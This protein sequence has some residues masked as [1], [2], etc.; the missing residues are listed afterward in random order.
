MSAQAMSA[1]AYREWGVEERPTSETGLERTKAVT[2]AVGLPRLRDRVPTL[3]K[4]GFALAT[5]ALVDWGLA[6]AGVPPGL[7]GAGGALATVQVMTGVV[8][9]RLAGAVSRAV[10]EKYQ[11]AEMADRTA[12]YV[13]SHANTPEDEQAH[14][15]RY[16]DKTERRV[17]EKRQE[18]GIVVRTQP[19]PPDISR[20][21]T[22][23]TQ[24]H[25][26]ATTTPPLAQASLAAEIEFADDQ[27]ELAD[28]DW[29]QHTESL[30]TPSPDPRA[31]RFPDRA[32]E[33]SLSA[34]ATTGQTP[35]ADAD[36]H[37]EPRPTL[38]PLEEHHTPEVGTSVG[39]EAPGHSL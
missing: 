32:P 8:H 13:V 26:G 5:G 14:L 20:Q 25:Q 17:A 1:S 6:K 3:T 38:S 31:E 12:E 7:S 4:A 35:S 16:F 30:D 23:V 10:P 9:N 11:E 29:V 15:A 21:E 19:G 24:Y 27:A 37:V 2:A 28:L 36:E 22:S 33:E 34:D 39:H 18:Q